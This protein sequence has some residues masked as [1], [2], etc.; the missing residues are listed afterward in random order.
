MKCK[1]PPLQQAQGPSGQ[2]RCSRSTLD[3][4]P[5]GPPIPRLQIADRPLTPTPTECPA[6]KRLHIHGISCT[7]KR[8]KL[9]GR[10]TN[11]GFSPYIRCTPSEAP[12][13]S[14]ATSAEDNNIHKEPSASSIFGRSEQQSQTPGVARMQHFPNRKLRNKVAQLAPTCRSVLSQAALLEI[15]KLSKIIPVPKR[16]RAKARQLNCHKPGADRPVASD[17]WCSSIRMRLGQRRKG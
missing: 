3:N 8:G 6:T 2:P 4:F 15:M 5:E 9:E 13:E 16:A 7:R 11:A 14:P 12:A 17:V 1:S 10:K